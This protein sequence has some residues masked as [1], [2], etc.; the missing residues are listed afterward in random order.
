MATGQTSAVKMEPVN[1]IGDW[2]TNATPSLH[3]SHI[4]VVDDDRGV[5]ETVTLLLAAAGYRT[6]TA[7]NGFEALQKLKAK[8]PSLMMCDLDMPDMSGFELLAIVRRRF[9]ALPVIAMS[10]LYAGDSVPEGVIADAFYGKGQQSPPELFRK[11]AD[12]LHRSAA[13]SPSR[14]AAP[15]PA[16]GRWLGTDTCETSYVLVPCDECLRSF[17]VALKDSSSTGVRKAHCIFCG[18]EI[19]YIYEHEA[20][21]RDYMS[22]VFKFFTQERVCMHE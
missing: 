2:R 20:S 19:Q 22:M 12:V 8:T 15:A 10:G 13:H 16:W 18:A 7:G 1:T 11:I 3:E 17:P 5:R 4:L 21:N 14:E 6:S 9:P